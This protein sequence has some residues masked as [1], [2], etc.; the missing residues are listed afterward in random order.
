MIEKR[1]IGILTNNKKCNKL[2]LK[3]PTL[4]VNATIEIK[5]PKCKEFNIFKNGEQYL[6]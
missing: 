1:C 2:L 4:R 3:T 6:K 5:C